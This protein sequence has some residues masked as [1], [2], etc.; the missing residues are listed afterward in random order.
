MDIP[1]IVSQASLPAYGEICVYGVSDEHTRDHIVNVVSRK[2]NFNVIFSNEHC[3]CVA[4]VA[5]RLN[6]VNLGNDARIILLCDGDSFSIYTFIRNLQDI[7]EPT[8]GDMILD[9]REP[10]RSPVMDRVKFSISKREKRSEARE[11]REIEDGISSSEAFFEEASHYLEDDMVMHCKLSE[12]DAPMDEMCIPCEVP[13]E[14]EIEDEKLE[15]QRQ[16]D[17]EDLRNAILAYTAKYHLDPSTILKELI[18]GKIVLNPD[19]FSRVVVNG[20]TEIVLAD[21]DET[22]VS[23]GAR[24]R[25]IYIFF[26]KHLEG[27]R[28]V[29]ICDYK[30]EL[31]D[32]YSVVKPGASD[33]TAQRTIGN[34]CEPFG[35]ALAQSLSKI[36]KAVKHTIQDEKTARQYYID[37]ERG[38]I[39]RISV[40]PELVTLPAALAN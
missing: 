37:G 35:S 31:L 30:D 7:E 23:M 15:R 17:I 24:E 34:I 11:Y 39:Y 36:K 26:L 29:D 8:T 4:Y 10:K 12:F 20:N 16:K 27:I 40:K 6:I 5:R 22:K 13:T 18:K 33:A 21:Y 9:K 14:D 25:T 32:I 1:Q 38:G 2:L 19:G 3:D 28:Q